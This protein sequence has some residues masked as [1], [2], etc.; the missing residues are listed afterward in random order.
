M[1]GVKAA[2]DFQ[3]KPMLTCHFENGRA[4]KNYV[5]STLLVLSKWNNKQ[6]SLDGS[7][8]VYNMFFFSFLY[9]VSHHTVQHGLLNILSP[10]L[11]PTAQVGRDSFQNVTAP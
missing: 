11:R 7:T 4:L 9:Y 6:R 2:G 10:L 8:S 1:L 3:L 5:K